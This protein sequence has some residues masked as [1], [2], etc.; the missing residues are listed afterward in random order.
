MTRVLFDSEACSLLDGAKDGCAKDTLAVYKALLH[1]VS[2][3]V[4]DVD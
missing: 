3:G 4:A 1:G 2:L